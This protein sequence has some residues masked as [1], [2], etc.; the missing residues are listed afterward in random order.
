MQG[1]SE[2]LADLGIRS[3]SLLQ[4]NKNLFDKALELNI[5]NKN[6]LEMLNKFTENPDNSM[7]EF[8]IQH[9]EFL[10]N[11]LNSSDAKTAKRAKACKEQ[12]LY[13]L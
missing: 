9:P 11:S 7:R 13:N 12:N 4:I 2:V 5:I 1:G 6:Q 10:E 8:L 3:L